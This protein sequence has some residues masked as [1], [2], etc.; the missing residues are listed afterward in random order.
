VGLTARF[1]AVRWVSAKTTREPTHMPKTPDNT[2]ETAP[3]GPFLTRPQAA[4]YLGLPTTALERD[5]CNRHLGVP[6]HHFGARRLYAK[7]D[8]DVWS[9]QHRAERPPKPGR[10]A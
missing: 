2:K 3:A 6:V 5:V 10:A 9:A 4:A 7:T 1:C 8:L